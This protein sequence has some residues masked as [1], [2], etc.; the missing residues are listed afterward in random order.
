MS[1]QLISRMLSVPPP[2]PNERDDDF[3][4]RLF[5]GEAF[6]C[7]RCGRAPQTWPGVCDA[8]DAWVKAQSATIDNRTDDDRV[9]ASGVPPVIA[10]A[11]WRHVRVSEEI[12][13]TLRAWTGDPTT[14]Y[15]WGPAGTGKSCVASCI[16]QDWIRNRQ[17]VR[18]LYV[19][20]WIDALREAEQD[21]DPIH[22]VRAVCNTAELVILDELITRRVTDYGADR[23][24]QVIE[25]RTANER[26]TV[27]TCNLP[28]HTTVSGP[29][30][31]KIDDRLASRISAGRQ[32]HMAGK[33][34][35]AER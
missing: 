19:P 30:V 32:V 18:W 8:C 15:L 29:D 5:D 23:L 1:D 9:L 24:L 11:A 2:Q 17:G 6:A 25:A 14:V 35:R 3:C 26:P 20:D 33:D 27:I 10:K 22:A 13:R 34:R 7:K 28:L 4:R 12:V 21:G 31:A 16:A